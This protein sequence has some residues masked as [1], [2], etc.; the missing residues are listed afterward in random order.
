MRSG[1]TSTLLRLA[2]CALICL[3]PQSARAQT[4]TIPLVPER[5][6]ATDSIRFETHLG[7]TALYINR[8]VA[9]ARDVELYDGVLE[10]SMAATPSTS[11]LGATFHAQRPDFAEILFFRPGQTGSTQAVQYGPAFNSLGAAWQVYSGDGA[12]ARAD[13]VR[14]R[15]IRVRLV[16]SGRT[17]TLFLDDA[18]QPTLVVPRLAGAGGGQLGVWTG[19]FG[20]GAYFTDFTYTPAPPAGTVEPDHLPPGTLTDWELSPVLD[21]ATLS[22]GTLPD[23][24]RVQWESVRAEPPGIVLISRYRTAAMASLPFDPTTRIIDV[25]SVMGGRVAGSKVV[26]ARTEIIADRAEMRRMHFGYSDGVIIYCN[27]RPLFFGMNAQFF[28]GDGIM[29]RIGDAVYLPLEAGRNEIVLAVTEFTG[30]WAFWARLDA[31]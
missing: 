11:F 12:N 4:D 3:T 8:G 10:F 2:T 29:S 1:F 9:L 22:P 27:G 16:L 17:A 19:L 31:T 15:W 28:R 18:Q 7:R 5:W 26:L 23:L 24:E 30:G 13:L 20:R 25:D 21:A 6:T 14:E